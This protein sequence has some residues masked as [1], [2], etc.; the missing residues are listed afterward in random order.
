M[1]RGVDFP[2]GADDQAP[3]PIGPL[4]RPLV[5]PVQSA[6]QER[7]DLV[8]HPGGTAPV[9][10]VERQRRQVAASGDV[11]PDHLPSREGD[12]VDLAD[13]GL[14]AEDDHSSGRAGSAL[15]KNPAIDSSMHRSTLLVEIVGRIS[16][17]SHVRRTD[18]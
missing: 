18:L 7:L 15:Q 12:A 6:A 5:A 14:D 17:P 4:L 2:F 1:G 11:P 13:L 16:N 9:V 3:G 10:P 8:A